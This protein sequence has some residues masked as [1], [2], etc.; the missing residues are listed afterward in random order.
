MRKLRPY[1]CA[2]RRPRSDK[3]IQWHKT[4]KLQVNVDS[5]WVC[6]GNIRKLIFWPSFKINFN[7]WFNYRSL[8]AILS[9]VC[10]QFIRWR[11]L[12][13]R[14]GCLGC[15]STSDSVSLSLSN[16]LNI[17]RQLKNSLTCY[18]INQTIEFT[19]TIHLYYPLN[20]Y[21]GVLFKINWICKK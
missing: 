13:G 3:Q 6:V 8:N 5:D 7:L 12:D 17:L 16:R 4:V 15:P 2:L 9:N 21:Y 1:L 19:L 18:Y 20:L 10:D 11:I 14:L